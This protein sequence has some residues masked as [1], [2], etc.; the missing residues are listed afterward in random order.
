[1][2]GGG[3][4]GRYHGSDEGKAEKTLSQLFGDHS[5]KFVAPFILPRNQTGL[6][7]PPGSGGG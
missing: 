1:M 7:Q 4:N 5:R 6:F 2:D 3:K